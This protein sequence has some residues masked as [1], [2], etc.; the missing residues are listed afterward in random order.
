MP[1]LL[2]GTSS[3]RRLPRIDVLHARTSPSTSAGSASRAAAS[4][5]ISTS[6]LCLLIAAPTCLCGGFRKRVAGTPWPRPRPRSKDRS[7][8]LD[9]L[10]GPIRETADHLIDT[11]ELTRTI[12][13][14]RLIA[15]FNPRC[16]RRLAVDQ[17]FKLQASVLPRG[18]DRF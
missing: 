4:A 17:S 5:L 18:A 15:C 2:D 6:D 16:T 10:V 1:R 9:L 14:P 13:A 11:S 7:A 3:G 8:K 12:C